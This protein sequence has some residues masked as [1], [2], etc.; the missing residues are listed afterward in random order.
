MSVKV[1]CPSAQPN[2]AGSEVFGV[3]NG[4]V[5]EPRVSYLTAPQETS[6]KIL[7]LTT[8]VEP[9]EVFRFAAP[10]AASACRHFVKGRCQLI[11]RVVE[12]LPEVIDQLPACSVRNDCRWWHQQGPD[13]CKRCPQI[14]TKSFAPSALQVRV[15][16]VG[17]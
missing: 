14:V 7:A 5:S 3:V 16:G 15:A 12:L 10:C 8:P 13:A 6:D 17:S 11:D 9:T 4:T 1:I 2:M